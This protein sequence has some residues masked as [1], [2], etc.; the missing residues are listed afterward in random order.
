MM[1]FDKVQ[2]INYENKTKN[3]NFSQFHIIQNFNI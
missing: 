3:E 2:I 1:Y